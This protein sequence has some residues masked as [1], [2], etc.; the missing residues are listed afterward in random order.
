MT[1]VSLQQP[2]LIF[3]NYFRPRSIGA[4]RVRVTPRELRLGLP[5]SVLWTMDRDV[6]SARIADVDDGCLWHRSKF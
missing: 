5:A 6:K 4:D 3:G 1:A 2:T